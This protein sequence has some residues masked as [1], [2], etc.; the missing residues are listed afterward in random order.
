V[1]VVRS[2]FV[3]DFDRVRARR[4]LRDRSAVGVAKIDRRVRTNGSDQRLYGWLRAG[5]GAALGA[6]RG[7]QD[8]DERDQ[9]GKSY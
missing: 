9:T 1:E 5:L 3:A 8:R 6:Q 7:R 4:E 2:G